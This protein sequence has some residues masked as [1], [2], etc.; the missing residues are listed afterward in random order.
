LITVGQGSFYVVK[1]SF[2]SASEVK[3]I[4]ITESEFLNGLKETAFSVF[5]KEGEMPGSGI[6]VLMKIAARSNYVLWDAHGTEP[7]DPLADPETIIGY[8]LHDLVPY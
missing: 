4:A 3:C 6:K 2:D 8:S 7:E 1:S 5:P